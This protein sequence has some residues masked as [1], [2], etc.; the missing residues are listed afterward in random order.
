MCPT[1]VSQDGRAVAAVGSVGGRRIPNAIFEVLYR[2]VGTGAS[3]EEAVAAPRLHTDG[4]LVIS[5]EPAVPAEQQEHMRQVGYDVRKG[6]AAVV[7]AV[8][9]DRSGLLR[10][11]S[12]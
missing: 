5:V 4:G 11:A 12:R 9:S 6:A 8:A 3:M 1:I 10:A 2:Y 7:H